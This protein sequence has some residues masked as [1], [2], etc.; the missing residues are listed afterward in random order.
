MVF[1]FFLCVIYCYCSYVSKMKS[2]PGLLS[3]GRVS[4]SECREVGR[5]KMVFR[6]FGVVLG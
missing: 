1:F 6:V 4:L 3:S 5:G 2:S